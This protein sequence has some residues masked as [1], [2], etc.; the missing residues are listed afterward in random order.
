MFHNY[1]KTSLEDFIEGLY[2]SKNIKNPQDINIINLS[3]QIG[4]NLEFVPIGSFSLESA[5][6]KWTIF[7]DTRISELKQR[8]DYLHELCH[9]LR[10]SGNQLVLPDTFIK[11]QEEEAEQFKNYALMPF[12][13]IERLVLPADYRQVVQYLS[14]VFSVSINRAK[15]RF[16]QIKRREFEE[17]TNRR[18]NSTSYE[19]V[20]KETRK[21]GSRFLAYY[22]PNE[23]CDGPTQMLV[24][25]DEHS[26]INEREIEIPIHSRLKEVDREDLNEF[27]GVTVSHGDLVCFDGVVTLQLHQLI[28]RYGFTKKNFVINMKEVEMMLARDQLISQKFSW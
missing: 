7:L 17:L 23:T 15:K 19:E 26:L 27:Y 11:Y 2:I 6:G 28:T 10:H 16:D 18:I 3:N 20:K 5:S 25:L 4:I 22:D 12:Y 14:L 8:D 9:L 13:M 21:F 24:C 1:R